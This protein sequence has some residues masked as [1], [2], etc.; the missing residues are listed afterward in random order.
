MVRQKEALETE[1]K[2]L[3]KAKSVGDAKE[4][5]LQEK[6]NRYRTAFK[7]TSAEAA[8]VPELQAQVKE[9]TE[10]LAQQSTTI[11]TLTE[12]VNKAQQLK[13]SIEGSKANERRLNEEVSRLTEKS[14]T[15]EAK[16]EGQTKTYTEKLQER[17]NLAKAYKARFIETLTRYVES[18]ANMLGVQPSEITSRLN[19]SYTL[20]DV[21][22]VCDKILESTVN[23]GRLPFG[24]RAKTS[25][26]IAESVSRPK[27]S[28]EEDDLSDL[29]ELAGLK[30]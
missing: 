5:E 22:A 10:K 26:R 11:K 25:A 27:N 8:K 2:D 17:T 14:K 19:E 20:K 13:E 21:D 15:L 28:Y 9:L 18:K 3:R 29:Y 4:Q 16:L 6:L 23:F 1:V 7:N 12:K 30:K 24:G